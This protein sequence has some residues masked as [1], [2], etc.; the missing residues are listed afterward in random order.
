M[1]NPFRFNLGDTLASFAIEGAKRGC[2]PDRPMCSGCAFKNGTPANSEVEAA[3]N[4]LDAL[5]T[6]G[7]EFNCHQFR[8]HRCTGYLLAQAAQD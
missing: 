2:K 1:S 7:I 5:L 3:E 8:E 4:A 6:D